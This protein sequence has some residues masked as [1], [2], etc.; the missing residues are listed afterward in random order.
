MRHG[1]RIYN[2]FPL[3]A[4]RI[5]NWA[6]LLPAIA[7]MGFDWV[8]LNPF[9][10]PGFS[11]SLYAVKDYERIHPLLADADAN[12]ESVLAAFVKQAR[13][14]GLKVMMDLVI[15]HTSKDSVLVEQCPDA[16]LRD[17]HGELVSP[18]AIDPADARKVTVWG[19]L[20]ELDYS[21]RPAREK[22]V[23]RWKTLL[24]RHIAMGFEGFRCDAAYQLPGDVWAELIQHGRSQGEIAQRDVLFLAET[25]GCRLAQMQQL[26][27]AGFDA[28][29]NSAKWWDFREPW[30]LE[31]Y[32]SFRKIAPSI[33]FPESHD[34]QRL[35]TELREKG[36]GDTWRIEAT[37]RLRYLFSVFFS[38]GVMMPMGFE[39]AQAK[40][41][42]VVKSRPEDLEAPLFDLRAFIGAANAQKRD[43]CVLCEEGPQQC[44]TERGSPVVG[45]LRTR[46]HGPERCLA[47]INPSPNATCE[48]SVDNLVH[49]VGTGWRTVCD[50][51]LGAV[52]GSF[53]PGNTLRFHPLSM[54][55]L[56]ANA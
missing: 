52:E 48:L 47:L 11:G 33:A 39:T 46:E 35:A 20:A 51:N 15:N 56:H 40:K 23:A 1:P 28:F 5:E 19:D 6:S 45:L 44:I 50:T 29:F 26:A 31:Q 16:Y 10:Y 37:Y 9:H 3:L 12:P 17:A 54:R 18:S 36:M 42:D 4:G 8:Y 34:T 32:E 24:T 30:L 43:L 38:S 14:H 22:L 25:L 49:R 21:P 53:E 41:L 27:N 55:L 13:D 2:L 7:A